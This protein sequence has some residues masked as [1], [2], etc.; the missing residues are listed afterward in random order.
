MSV[1]P[2]VSPANNADGI[3]LMPVITATYP[4]SLDEG[5]VSTIN[6]FLVKKTSS[7]GTNST[8]PVP[9]R[10][11]LKR[12]QLT[13]SSEYTGV[14]YGNGVDA[15][16]KYRSLIEIT[17]AASLDP[18][19]AY[20][21]ILSKDIGKTSVFD[22]KANVTN[23]GATSPLAKGPFIGLGT[24][25]YK[26][27]VVIGGNE[28]TSTYKVVRLSDNYTINNL[29]A[30]KRFIELEKGLFLKFPTGTYVA[31]DYYNVI[32]KP[33]VKT[34]EI[35]SWDFTTGDSNYTQPADEN[36]TIIVGLPVET[37]S[38]SVINPTLPFKL[39]SI[40]PAPNSIMNSS[41]NRVVTF[42][43]NKD[44]KPDSITAEKIKLIAESTTTN[45]YGSLDYTF[46]V[47]DNKLIITFSE[48]T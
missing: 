40:N 9:I 26:I 15:G 27:E 33:V 38:G 23:V 36:S 24:D 45:Y 14:D 31:G 2:L 44:I 3:A 6:C 34:N 22:V 16:N 28:N 4:F 7:L 1:L 11:L 12:L 17:S 25:Q 21:V 13:N 8:T 19:S 48:G 18:H 39:L 41:A 46:A 43:F 29:V 10:V 20:S 5:S 42:T 30:K 47:Q 35:Y 37:N 32:V